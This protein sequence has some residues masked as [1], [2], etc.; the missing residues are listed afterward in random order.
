VSNGCCLEKILDFW[1]NFLDNEDH[2][3]QGIVFSGLL[4]LTVERRHA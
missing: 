3:T 2:G 4:S 1:Q